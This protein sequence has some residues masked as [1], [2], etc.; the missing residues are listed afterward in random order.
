MGKRRPANR[1]KG[2]TELRL[3]RAERLIVIGWALAL[4]ILLYL[5][6]PKNSRRATEHVA[7]HGARTP[8]DTA[9]AGREP[10]KTHKRSTDEAIS[11]CL[12]RLGFLSVYRPGYL[13]R[14]TPAERAGAS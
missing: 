12:G 1:K 5:I 11:A 7:A 6:I 14:I 8:S 2:R 10:Q 3:S 9:V 4:F 13:T